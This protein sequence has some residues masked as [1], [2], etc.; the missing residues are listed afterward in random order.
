MEQLTGFISVI[1]RSVSIYVYPMWLEICNETKTNE[2]LNSLFTILNMKV[3]NILDYNLLEYCI[4]KFGDNDLNK[5]MNHY[6][7]ELNKFK[8]ETLVVKFIECWEGHNRE[9]PNYG[10]VVI[11]FD[12]PTVTLADLDIFRKKLAKNC[13]P[14]LVN[15]AEWIYYNKFQPGS[16]VISWILPN[17]LAKLLLENIKDIYMLLE[18]YQV[19]QVVLRGT[20][21]YTSQKPCHGG[22]HNWSIFL[23]L[24]SKKMTI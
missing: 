16:F 5:R 23:L 15:C 7:S 6:I 12:I 4:A 11:T 1:P 9:I 13:F 18:E 21:I 17:Q 14:S 10:E 24:V 19:R 3:W 8:E 22:K 2:T 20:A